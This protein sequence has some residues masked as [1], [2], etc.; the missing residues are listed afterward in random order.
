MV[1]IDRLAS[2]VRATMWVRSIT[3]ANVISNVIT[4]TFP[5]ASIVAVADSMRSC[6]SV[7]VT[8]PR[9]YVMYVSLS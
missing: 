5:S 8:L 2:D 1:S 9:L 3:S 7:T 6:G 4:C